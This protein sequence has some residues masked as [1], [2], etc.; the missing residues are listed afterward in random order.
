MGVKEF[1]PY[2]QAKLRAEPTDEALS[3]GTQALEANHFR[4][5]TSYHSYAKKQIKWIRGLQAHSPI[6]Q[7]DLDTAPSEALFAEALVRWPL[8]PGS[9][10]VLPCWPPRHTSSLPAAGPDCADT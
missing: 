3:K 9:S 4:Y 10:S 2:L 6:L 5:P 1:L 8:M 7:L